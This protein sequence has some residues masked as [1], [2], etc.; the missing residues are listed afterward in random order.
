MTDT[1]KLNAACRLAAMAYR[2]TVDELARRA[3]AD[4]RFIDNYWP[5][6]FKQADTQEYSAALDWAWNLAGT[7]AQMGGTKR[8]RPLL[9]EVGLDGQRRKAASDW[10]YPLRPLSPS[11]LFPQSVQGMQTALQDDYKG[12]WEAFCHG[13]KRVPPSHR[14]NLSL[15]LD[16]VDSLWLTYAHAI[17]LADA[18]ADISL[19]D[20][21]KITAALAVAWWAHVSQQPAAP[22]AATSVDQPAFLLV[23]GDLSGIQDFI[24]AS[25]GETQKHAPKLLRGRSFYVS[26]LTELATL[27]ILDALHLPPTSQVLNAAGKLTIVAPN[28]T[29][30]E[31][32]LRR[33]QQDLDAWF[34]AHCF[35]QTGISLAWTA[36]CGGDLRPGQGE[37]QPFRRLVGRLFAASEG[38]R[39]RRFALCGDTSAPAVFH[40]FLDRFAMGLC[41]IDGRSLATDTRP[42]KDGKEIAVCQLANDQIEIGRFLAKSGQRILITRHNLRHHTLDLPIFGYWVSFS[43][44]EEETGKFGP[45]AR[46]GTLLRC[47]DYG[48]PESADAPLWTGYARRYINAYVP[49]FEPR[50]DD[51]TR[52]SGLETLGEGDIKPL[53]FLARDDCSLNEQG[54]WQGLDALMTL[55]GDVD[56]LGRIFQQGFACPSFIRM[57][58]LSRQM[59]AFF[60]VYLPWLC[61]QRETEGQNY[62]N[63][64]TVFAGGDDFFLIG[65]WHTTLQLACRMRQDF[66]RYV[67]EN[68]ALHFSA[69]LS[70]SKPGLP[71]RHLARQAEAALEYAKAYRV[72]AK[73]SPGKNAVTLFQRTVPWPTLLSLLDNATELARLSESC[74]L[75][76]GYL[77]DLLRYAN[78]AG[79]VAQRPENALWHS[80]FAYRTR[81]LVETRIKG[82]DDRRA[83]ELRRRAMQLALAQTIAN[84]GIETHQADYQIALIT[85]LYRQRAF[86]ARG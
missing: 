34:L 83:T 62:R 61:A 68:P 40:G 85:H 8:L 10:A 9:A 70:L 28:T 36:A 63:V 47:W 55:K 14:D 37:D 4:S 54:G 80:Q 31:E 45:Q 52:Y 79:G 23:Q 13:L 84:G 11:G 29:A 41:Q 22:T 6:A 59:N 1:L 64:Y 15:W 53:D 77:Y 56:N 12:L 20:Y 43:E 26:L 32:A 86:Q 69:G 2:R 5:A 73:N 51:A 33:V 42:D 67:A 16:H 3:G 60:A 74:Q 72:P 19:Y 30:T 44:G 65:P 82:G 46:D 49:L 57:A 27:K 18:T 76:S 39:L 17:P 24:F 35:G 7:G 71:I 75:S 25:G 38:A 50:D 48:L 21:A 66:V 81:R 78:M 58:A